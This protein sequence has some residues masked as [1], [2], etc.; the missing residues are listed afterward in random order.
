MERLCELPEEVREDIMLRLSPDSLKHLKLT[1]KW[2]YF[3]I[4]SLVD[5]PDFVAKHLRN[6]KNNLSSARNMIIW[7]LL[8]ISH[9]EPDDREAD[10]EGALLVT[11]ASDDIGGGDCVPCVTDDIKFLASDLDKEFC[12]VVSNCNGIICLYAH[13]EGDL[14][15]LLNPSQREFKIVLNARDCDSVQTVGFGYDS[16]ANDY[17]VVAIKSVPCTNTHEESP[18][19]A[20][21]YTLT[22]DSWKEIEM[23]DEAIDFPPHDHQ[24][25]YCNGVCYW[26]FLSSEF[27]AFDVHDEEF[28]TL[29]L[30]DQGSRLTEWESAEELSK[31][32]VWNDS[33][34]FFLYVEEQPM[35]IDMWVLEYGVDDSYFWVRHQRIGPL[36]D[37]SSPL[38]F[39]QCDILLLKT[40]SGEIVSCNIR[41]KMISDYTLQLPIV[42]LVICEASLVSV[43][44]ER[45]R[46][47]MQR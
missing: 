41:A 3:Y 31:I 35:F 28:F 29:E 37:I 32:A 14:V 26:Y 6:M 1:R 12:R 16:K 18:Y 25:L 40:K 10:V 42:S 34:V 22:T 30:P 27:I 19:K 5:D 2:W 20:E 23:D 43:L 38:A 24:T 33:L 47:L 46:A 9:E 36:V 45:Q 7:N 13:G 39:W 11:V 8:A 21:L 17:K 44:R 4:N 15:A